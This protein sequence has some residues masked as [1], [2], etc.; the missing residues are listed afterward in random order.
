[1]TDAAEV[2]E[3]GR[4]KNRD[5]ESNRQDGVDHGRRAARG[6]GDR[7]RRCTAPARTSSST[8]ASPRREAAALAARAE[9]RARQVRGHHPGGPARSRQAAGARGI[10]GA[11]L[12]RARRA[13]E[14]RLDVLPD[15]DRRDHASR[16]GT[17]CSARNLKVAAVPVAGGGARAAASRSGLILNIVDIHALRPLRN[18]TV[19]CTAKAGLHMLTRSLAKELG[20]EIRVNGISPGPVLW[21][22]GTAA[23]KP[24]ARRSSSERSCKRMG[25]PADI[26]RTALFFAAARAV[27]HRADPR[28]R[29]RP[30]RRLVERRCQAPFARKRCLRTIAGELGTGFI[31]CP[32]RSNSCHN[33]PMVL[34][35]VGCTTSGAISAIGPSM[36]GR[37]SRS[38]RGSV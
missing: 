25:T 19:Y 37:L 21:P 14:Q 10:R 22:E 12:R 7:A 15:E 30:Q 31:A 9:R 36:Y 5:G 18:Y 35:A 8:T 4:C 20:P 6:R 11:Q 24:R 1:M 34:L 32:S 26:A 27:H 38:G 29:R 33:S 17:I 28:R 16:P 3:C 23:T 13:R 2:I